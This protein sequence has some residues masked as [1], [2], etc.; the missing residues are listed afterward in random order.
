MQSPVNLYKMEFVGYHF[1]YCGIK[2]LRVL[3]IL[4]RHLEDTWWF[5]R[6]L[7]LERKCFCRQRMYQISLL[8][9]LSG[10]WP[11]YAHAVTEESSL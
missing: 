7:Y 4:A 11:G 9:S 10:H 1:E 8:W 6:V 2:I 3:M 5:W